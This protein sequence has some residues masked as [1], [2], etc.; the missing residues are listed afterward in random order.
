M[1]SISLL[2]NILAK[3]QAI[4]QNAKEAIMFE[5]GNIVTEGSSS[6]IFIVNN[7]GSLQT[8]PANERILNGITRQEIIKSVNN[9]DIKILEKE[10]FLDEML[11]ARE[12]F[13]TSTSMKLIPIT[14]INGR[15]IADGQVGQMS[16][17]LMNL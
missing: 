13:L 6:N 8:H 10:F 4:S 1:K 7:E 2:P 14:Q 5:N 17:K 11:G 16:K 15:K 9:N 12:V 3:Q